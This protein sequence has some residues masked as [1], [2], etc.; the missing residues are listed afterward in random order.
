MGRPDVSG[1]ARVLACVVCGDDS[2]FIA[3]ASS[4]VEDE[5][6]CSRCGQARLVTRLP[7]VHARR[8]A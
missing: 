2:E 8:L 5:L 3:V 6:M 7:M 1:D 4:E